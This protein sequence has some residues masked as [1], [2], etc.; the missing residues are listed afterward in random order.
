MDFRFK[1]KNPFWSYWRR[2]RAW[3]WYVDRFGLQ[4]TPTPLPFPYQMQG[5]S[6]VYVRSLEEVLDMFPQQYDEDEEQQQQAGVHTALMEARWHGFPKDIPRDVVLKWK[7][8][9]EAELADRKKKVAAYAQATAASAQSHGRFRNIS[10]GSVIKLQ[11]F[12]RIAEIFIIFIINRVH[13]SKNH[14]FHLFKS[15]NCQRRILYL[16]DGIPYFDFHPW[17]HIPIPLQWVNDI[18]YLSFD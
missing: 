1:V 16:G 5:L 11:F 17:Q 13:S 15:G 3:G 14:W 9:V 4:P 18:S 2:S 12:H 10:Q 7:A 8:E 6:G